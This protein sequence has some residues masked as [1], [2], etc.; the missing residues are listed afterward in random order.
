MLAED[1]L[2]AE[3]KDFDFDLKFKVTQFDVTFSGATGY[4]KTY[5]ATGNRFTADQKDQFGKMTQGSIIFID[6]ITAKGDDGTSRQLA[7]IS[8]KIR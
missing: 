7:P 3:L 4:V 5:K 1:G 2:F 8:F 6:N